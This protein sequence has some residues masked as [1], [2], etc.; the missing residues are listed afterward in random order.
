MDN[1]TSPP[2][3]PT[4]CIIKLDQTQYTFFQQSRLVIHSPDGKFLTVVTRPLPSKTDDDAIYQLYC[5]AHVL[6]VLFD[7]VNEH[8]KL[9]P[10]AINSIARVIDRIDRHLE[11]Q[12]SL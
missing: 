10:W 4:S 2:A 6:E 9:P 3:P 7:D 5:Q 11:K 1:V 8:L 12:L